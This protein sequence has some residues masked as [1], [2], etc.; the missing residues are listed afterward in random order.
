MTR[1]Q[2]FQDTF[3][4]NRSSLWKGGPEERKEGGREG[5]REMDRERDGERGG[6]REGGRK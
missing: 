2:D 1:Q 5:E 6:G 4:T 3:S